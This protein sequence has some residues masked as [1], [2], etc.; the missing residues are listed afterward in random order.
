MPQTPPPRTPAPA[1][2]RAPHARQRAAR[3]FV[4]K[5]APLGSYEVVGTLLLAHA[6]A[7]KEATPRALEALVQ[8][9]TLSLCAARALEALA[10]SAAG[11]AAV[12]ARGVGAAL[13]CAARDA[14]GLFALAR[15][16]LCAK[17][18]FA[19]YMY[20][21]EA[22]APRHLVRRMRVEDGR[23]FTGELVTLAGDPTSLLIVA[24][25]RAIGRARG[26]VAY[27]QLVALRV[28]A[29]IL[30]ARDAQRSVAD[31]LGARSCVLVDVLGD[32]APEVE[33]PAVA[34]PVLHVAPTPPPVC[35]KTLATPALPVCAK[36]LLAAA[37]A[38]TLQLSAPRH[39]VPKQRVP[40]IAMPF[41]VG[42]SPTTHLITPAAGGA[43]G[44]TPGALAGAQR[45]GDYMALLAQMA[46][47]GFV[48]GAGV[49]AMTGGASS[50]SLPAARSLLPGLP[51]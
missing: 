9:N 18:Q 23:G 42:E 40:P 34:P 29:V 22:F 33:R 39:T 48:R 6:H 24:A 36:T 15:H 30:G 10:E 51:N 5:A 49:R 11:P 1:R 31:V 13:A 41:V 2:T 26:L 47:P 25:R 4:S 43:G 27:P 35:A 38:K 20:F 17:Q 46:A 45:A 14:D 28:G 21:V 8:K 44:A 12:R 7:Q 16:Y 3:R 50:W 19:L 37:A 32:G